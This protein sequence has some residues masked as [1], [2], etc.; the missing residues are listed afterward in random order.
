MTSGEHEREVTVSWT[1]GMRFEART[2]G[3]AA[4]ALDGEGSLNPSPPEMLLAALGGCLGIDV[5]EILRKGRHEPE[6]LSVEVLGT[7]REEDPRSFRRLEV[8]FR[9]RGE[10]PVPT[11]ERAVELSLETYC[12]VYHTLDPRIELVTEVEVSGAA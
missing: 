9:V 3:G 8:T 11:V 12:S 2:A 10:V 5:V 4:A 1:E 7:R 6:A